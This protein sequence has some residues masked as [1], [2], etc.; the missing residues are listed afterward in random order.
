MEPKADLALT[1]R[2]VIGFALLTVGLG[3]AVLSGGHANGALLAVLVFAVPGVLIA[4][5]GA[6]NE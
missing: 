1:V 5:A 3:F 4:S 6:P 2:R